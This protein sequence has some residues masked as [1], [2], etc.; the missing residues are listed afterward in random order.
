M[1]DLDF[2]DPTAQ[3]PGRADSGVTLPFIA[4]IMVTLL[5][6]AAFAIDLGWF[7]LNASRIQRAAD[8][9]AL[10]GVIHMPND[11][12][13]ASDVAHE[14]ALSNGYEDLGIPGTYP[15]VVAAGVPA[16]PT[17]LQ[18]TVTD[19][20]PT[21]FLKVFGIS[22]QIITRTAQAEFVPP[23]PLGS[24]ANQFGNS[25][26]PDA[27]NCPNQPNFWANIHGRFTNTISGDAFSSA[28]SGTMGSPC[29]G[30]DANPTFRDDTSKRPGYLYG[31]EA[32]GASSFTVEFNDVVFRNISA[33]QTTSDHIRTGDRGCEDWGDNGVD[34]GPTVR[35][36]LFPPDATPL[37]VTDSTAMCTQ[38]ITP[39]PQ[40]AEADPY[41]WISPSGC[42]TVNNPEAGI[43][44][45]QVRILSTG[46]M[47]DGYNRYALR[48]MPASTRL[49]A[50]GDMSIYNNSEISVTSFHLAEVSP[51]YAGKTFVVELYDAGDSDKAGTLQVIAPGG[52][53]FNG[54]C[55]ISWRPS[56]NADWQPV[57]PSS[58]LC[59]EPVAV[60]EYN[61][62]WLK[63]EMDLS[64][65]Y[66]CTDCWW[67]MNYDYS[68]GTQ[69]TTTWRAYIL[70]NPIH[71]VPT[72]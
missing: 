49:Y 17:Q 15:T 6:I 56:V 66:S 30:V 60:Q 16:E 41:D 39:Q 22:S 43:Y 14:I 54:T 47:P 35:V 62:D 26:A 3:H 40:I 7:Y 36:T 59:E 63:F 45:L 11:P 50:I 5:G 53:V 46:S 65:T 32:K 71:L 29:S 67:M 23:L 55:R 52:S 42:F 2:A 1:T 27:V 44:V 10:A 48:S 61:G 33:G 12:T 37:D 24:P 69:D 9:S 57:T 31:I 8:A 13:E 21:F 68:G 38:D 51:I 20:V 64:S 28:C 18:V 34:C 70:G 4:L 19:Q 58:A 25:C 72:S